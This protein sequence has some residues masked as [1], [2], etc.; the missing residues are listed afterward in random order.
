MKVKGTETGSKGLFRLRGTS[1]TKGV[2][3]NETLFHW[4]GRVWRRRRKWV[5][6][7]L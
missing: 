5:V 7:F 6:K 1:G 4:R 2:K 3:I